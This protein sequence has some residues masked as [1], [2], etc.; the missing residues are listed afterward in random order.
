M[1]LKICALPHHSVDLLWVKGHSG[2]PGNEI[3]NAIA[4]QVRESDSLYDN[5]E[6]SVSVEDVK[7][8]LREGQESN[9]IDELHAELASGEKNSTLRQLRDATL[10]RPNPCLT[11]PPSLS[12][13]EELLY[14]RIVLNSRPAFP[15]GWLWN[16][17]CPWCGGDLK[18]SHLLKREGLRCEREGLEVLSE[19]GAF[20]DL[21]TAKR[22]LGRVVAKLCQ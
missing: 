12:R 18:G 3:A 17:P 4:R 2:V 8:I 14:N 10:F 5:G 13:K 7:S 21:G 1:Q 15:G 6:R 20:S 22:F 9:A 11:G 16:D 19:L